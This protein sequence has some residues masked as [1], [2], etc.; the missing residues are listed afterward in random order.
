[1]TQGDG[2]IREEGIRDSEHFSPY[3]ADGKLVSCVSFVKDGGCLCVNWRRGKKVEK[4]VRGRWDICEKRL[5]DNTWQ[6]STAS[7]A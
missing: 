7:C 3:R 6:Y 4:N 1:M 5:A 2:S